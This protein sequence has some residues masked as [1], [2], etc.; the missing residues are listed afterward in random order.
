MN[1]YSNE[2]ILSQNGGLPYDRA[3]EVLD[4]LSVLETLLEKTNEAIKRLYQFEE[5]WDK[6]VESLGED[7]P[8]SDSDLCLLH[9][10]LKGLVNDFESI[11]EESDNEQ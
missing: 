4:R 8:E 1:N 7:A 6:Y 10:K 9:N 2:E 11:M 3:A 5:N